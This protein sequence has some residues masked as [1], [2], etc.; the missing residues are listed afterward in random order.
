MAATTWRDLLAEAVA[1][2]GDVD[3]RRIVAEASGLEPAEWVTG[4][5]APA[6]ERGVARFEQLL[7]RRSAGEPLQYVLGGWGFR[8]VD[9]MVDRRVLIPRPETEVVA[10]L[11]LDAARA[12]PAPTVVDLGTGSGAIALSIAAELYDHDQEIE[13]WATDVSESALEVARANLA[14]I[15]RAATRVRCTSGDWYAALDPALA[16]GVDVIVSNPPYVSAEERDE[17]PVEVADWEPIGALVSGESGLECLE[18]VVSGAPE[19]LAP[20]GVLVV[21][22]DPRQATTVATMAR[23][24]GFA[25]AT[26]HPDLTGRMRALVAERT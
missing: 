19:W 14:G 18:A 15:G 24:H 5:D 16:G 1:A 3:G 17:L 13:V 7:R 21:E 2:V 9:L 22:L 10:G 6:P 20:E 11:A 8:T 25:R 12:R 23:D 26:I 4:L